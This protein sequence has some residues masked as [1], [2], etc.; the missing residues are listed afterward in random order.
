MIWYLTVPLI[1][2]FTFKNL[3]QGDWLDISG[4]WTFLA[5]VFTIFA[6]CLISLLI[7]AIPFGLSC[8]IGSMPN[9]VG[10]PNSPFPLIALREK[11]GIQGRSYFLGAGFINDTQYYFWYRRS[12]DGSISGGKT[13]RQPEVRIYEEDSQPRM[14]TFHTEYT[15]PLAEKWLWVVGTDVRD[16]EDWCPDFYI[17]K[18]SIKEGFSL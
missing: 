2:F 17:P 8:W 16:D 4:R 18:G 14:V 7:S 3:I 1:F 15:N 9:R 12:T 10:K 6:G 5:A 13:V 11:D